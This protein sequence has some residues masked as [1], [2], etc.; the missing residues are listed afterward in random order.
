VLPLSKRR[1]LERLIAS[2]DRKMNI[3]QAGLDLITVRTF[4]LVRKEDI[5]GVSGTGVVAVGAVFPTGRVI[6]EWLP[7]RVDVRSFNIYNSIEELELVNG[8]SG[9]TVVEWDEVK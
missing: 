5:S 1:A 8:H 4:R 9:A 3:G 7:G 6:T 2:F